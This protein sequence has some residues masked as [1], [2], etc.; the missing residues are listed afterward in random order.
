MPPL[1]PMGARVPVPCPPGPP[2][3]GGDCLSPVK[4]RRWSI[5]GF[6]PFVSTSSLLLLRTAPPMGV[7]SCSSSATAVQFCRSCLQLQQ[8]EFAIQREPIHA[9]LRLVNQPCIRECSAP[10]VEPPFIALCSHLQ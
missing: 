3:C 7:C 4:L 8:F 1:R 9:F 6:A 5:C 10:L 2:P